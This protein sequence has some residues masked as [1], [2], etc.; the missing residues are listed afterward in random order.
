MW[1]LLGALCAPTISIFVGGIK[2][3]LA[4]IAI[5][6]L[7]V[8][9]LSILLGGSRRVVA[10]D[11]FICTMAAWMIGATAVVEGFSTSAFAE[12]LEFLGAYLVAR[13]YVFG[14]TG[15]FTFVKVLKTTLLILVALA[16]LD[17]ISG[18][19]ITLEATAAVLP[20]VGASNAYR[21]DLVRASSTFDGS[22]QFGTFCAVTAAIFLYSEQRLTSRFLYVALS[23]LG[24]VLALSSAPLMGLF[25]V[26]GTWAYDWL[27]RWY[28]PRWKLFVMI[29]VGLTVILFQ[30]S[31]DPV[32]SIIGHL[33]FD[34]ADGWYRLNTW[35][36]QMHNIGLSPWVGYGFQ[37]FG[38]PED[39]FDQASV[40]AVWLVVGLCFGL[41]A[42]GL[43]ISTNIASFAHLRSREGSGPYMDRMGTS[44]TLAIIT[45]MFVGLTVH[46]WHHPWMLWGLFIGVRA[47]L[48]E[49]GKLPH[50]V[51]LLSWKLKRNSALP[52]TA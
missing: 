45:W 6:C 7:L 33:T 46:Y 14:P 20:G 4:R 22:I 27:L 21:L 9:A 18:R 39:Y 42:V 26:M 16:I 1:L 15:V 44:F 36:H 11:F 23:A 35:D 28:A 19:N 25:I 29:L 24:C 5:A 3:T 43:L 10:S 40:D 31:N 47:S 49:Y 2:L 32:S 17:T 41:P 12:V 30:V 52:R 8:P 48:K 50:E 13:A 51:K 37:T 38:N 34:P